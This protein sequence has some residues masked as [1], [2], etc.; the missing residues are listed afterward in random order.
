MKRKRCAKR[1]NFKIYMLFECVVYCVVLIL[2]GSANNGA[3]AGAFIGN[4][5]NGVS[6]SNANIGSR[7]CLLFKIFYISAPGLP[8]GNYLSQYLS[9]L[10]LTYFDHWVKEDLKVKYYFRY[11]DDMVILASEKRALWHYFDEISRYLGNEL[12]LMINGNY[13]VFPIESRGVDFVGYVFYHTHTRLRKSIKKRFARKVA[14]GVSRESLAS[15]MGWAKHCN[16][17][18]LVNKLKKDHEG[19]LRSL[20]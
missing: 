15:Y 13:Q 17:K 5:N 3:N 4:A 14:S 16:S 9:N 18:M 1:A 8:I 10:Y 20:A 6:N 11:A 7:L 2:G 19:T 12:K